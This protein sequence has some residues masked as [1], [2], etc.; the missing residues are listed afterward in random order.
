M[1]LYSVQVELAPPKPPITYQ[2]NSYGVVVCTI[3]KSAVKL[4]QNLKPCP[5]S[6]QESVVPNFYTNLYGATKLLST[7]FWAVVELFVVFM[8]LYML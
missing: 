5:I 7:T 1:Q 6:L 3:G 8:Y 4:H 2:W